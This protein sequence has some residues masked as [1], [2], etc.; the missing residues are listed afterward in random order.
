MASAEQLAAI[1]FPES[2][3]FALSAALDHH[4]AAN[5][6]HAGNDVL[7]LTPSGDRVLCNLSTLVRV[8][9]VEQVL[10][11]RAAAPH[12]HESTW[13]AAVAVPTICSGVGDDALAVLDHVRNV[14]GPCGCGVREHI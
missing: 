1:G 13:R 7:Q 11:L 8:A 10:P 9:A 3:K 12:L 5:S 2:L 6:T 14:L 4:L